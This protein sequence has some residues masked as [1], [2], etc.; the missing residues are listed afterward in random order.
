VTRFYEK[1]SDSYA[2]FDPDTQKIKTLD[3]TTSHLPFVETG[4]NENRG[5][6]AIM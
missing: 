5:S 1:S 6:D 2:P 3:M 4:A